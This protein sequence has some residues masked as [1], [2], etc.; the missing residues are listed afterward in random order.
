MPLH[1]YLLA[2]LLVLLTEATP[3]RAQD[4]YF[5]SLDGRFEQ[6]LFELLHIEHMTILYVEPYVKIAGRY[7]NMYVTYDYNQDSIL[8]KIEMTKN[9][10]WWPQLRRYYWPIKSFLVMAGGTALFFYERDN[11]Y[12]M[13][14]TSYVTMNQD[15]VYRFQT[16]RPDAANIDLLLSC[17]WIHRA[18]PSALR[19]FDFVVL[20]DQEREPADKP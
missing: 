5:F 8:W 1:R 11:W 20:G 15:R 17:T 10:E 14:L 19:D 12:R 6:T 3:A 16:K 18:P 7:G 9:Y 13:D 2:L 4:P